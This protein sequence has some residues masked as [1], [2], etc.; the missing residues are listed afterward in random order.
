VIADGVKGA[1]VEAVALIEPEAA[2][3]AVEG[4][5]R[6]TANLMGAFQHA[7]DPDRA[8]GRALKCYERAGITLSPLL[9]GGFAISGNAD[10]TTGATIKAAVEAAEPLTAGDTRNR[11]GATWTGCTGSAPTGWTPATRTPT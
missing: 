5:V 4:D 9:G 3:T 7:L 6:A 8:D 2:A 10:E 11:P 1:P